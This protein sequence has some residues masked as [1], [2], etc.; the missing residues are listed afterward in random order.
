[1]AD[2]SVLTPSRN[3][4]RFIED[5]VE[6]VARQD[7]VSV[8]HIVQ[9]AA[10]GDETVD[11]LRRSSHSID[12]RSEADGGQSNA[13]NRALSRASSKWIAWLNADEFYL[14]GALLHLIRIAE[15]MNADVVYGDCAVVDVEGSLLRLLPEHRFSARVLKEYGCYISSAC[16]LFRRSALGESPWDESVRRV[17][18]WDLFMRLT[19]QEAKFVHTAWPVAAFRLHESQ[20]TAAPHSAFH[21]ENAIVTARYGRPADPVERWK[22]SRAGRVLHRVYKAY[23]GAYVRQ[24]RGRKL[25][26]LDLRWF[27]GDDHRSSTEALVRG[28][29]RGVGSRASART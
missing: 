7:G 11:I 26:G 17:M 8:E 28:C 22:A 12:W 3:Y 29:Y 27:R 20:V 21:A 5:A 14:D 13:L 9:D 4:G 18:D 19:A 23:D 24:W 16:T 25:R 15:R 6:S 10:S 2:V 1:M